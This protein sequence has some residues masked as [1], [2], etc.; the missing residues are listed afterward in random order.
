MEKTVKSKKSIY[1]AIISLLFFII[2]LAENSFLFWKIYILYVVTL[3]IFFVFGKVVAIKKSKKNKEKKVKSV[4]S[5]IFE[6]G[7]IQ[8]GDL[9]EIVSNSN[10]DYLSEGKS[11]SQGIVSAVNSGMVSV[12]IKG[13]IKIIELKHLNKINSNNLKF[14]E[15]FFLGGDLLEK[16]QFSKQSLARREREKFFERLVQCV[17]FFKNGDFGDNYN[18]ISAKFSDYDKIDEY[19]GDLKVLISKAGIRLRGLKYEEL[20]VELA[21]GLLFDSEGQKVLISSVDALRLVKKYLNID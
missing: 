14:K 2:V 17:D 8:E 11:F 15:L 9:V 10:S 16:L 7:K 5:E 12:Q 19:F 21:K 20:E 18:A 6:N 3:F 1:I 13:E 4:K